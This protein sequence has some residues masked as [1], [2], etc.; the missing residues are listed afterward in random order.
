MRYVPMRL[1]LVDE[2]FKDSFYR[3]NN[4]TMKTNITEKEGNYLF[5]IEVPGVDK[6]DI[7]VELERGYLNI[8]VERDENSEEKDD[9][10]TVIRQERFTG[11]CRRSYYIGDEYTD[12][13]IVA[14]YE[15]GILQVALKVKSPE[16]IA[17]KKIIAIN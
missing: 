1:G 8:S 16:E 6:E 12:E 11:S 9:K 10:G 15:N 7:K 13:D 5:D 2:M 17:N 4:L 3:H 14:K